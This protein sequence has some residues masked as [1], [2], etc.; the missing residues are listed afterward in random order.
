MEYESKITSIIQESIISKED[1]LFCIN[2]DIK[3]PEKMADVNM[4]GTI[5]PSFNLQT[6]LESKDSESICMSVF[7]VNDKEL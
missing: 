6:L 1:M 5:I 7:D 2:S 3:A 4:N